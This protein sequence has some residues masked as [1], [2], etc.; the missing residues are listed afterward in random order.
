MFPNRLVTTDPTS[1]DAETPRRPTDFASWP[2]DLQQSISK[3]P[4]E[5]LD[6]LRDLPQEPPSAKLDPDGAF[7]MHTLLSL[8]DP[9][10]ARRWHWKDTRK[11]LRSLEIIHE[12]RKR[13]SDIVY[14]QS[15][16]DSNSTPRFV[17]VPIGPLDVLICP[18]D[19]GRCASGSLQ[20][21]MLF[22]PGLT[23]G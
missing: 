12:T 18:L 20:R 6:L 13:A 16:D 5:L 1:V 19:T 11:V 8:L 7:Q 14:D 23:H 17:Q 22:I 4:P 21:T 10:I 2:E 3:L 9:V 15:Q